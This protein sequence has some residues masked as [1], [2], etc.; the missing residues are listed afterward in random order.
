M[1]LQLRGK[2]RARLDHLI[3]KC[4]DLSFLDIILSARQETED[5]TEK[6]RG[7]FKPEFKAKVAM[8]AQGALSDDGCVCNG[9]PG[10]GNAAD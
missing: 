4:G 5:M 1:Q 9:A 8:E 7:W 6:S 2:S 10:G 3:N